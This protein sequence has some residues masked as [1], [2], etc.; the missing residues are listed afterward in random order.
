MDAA[1]AAIDDAAG[2][3]NPERKLFFVARTPQAISGD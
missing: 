2:F 3:N 1:L